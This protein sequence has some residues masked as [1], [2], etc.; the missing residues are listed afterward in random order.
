MAS[1]SSA[2]H[3]WKFIQLLHQIR[4]SLQLRSIWENKSLCNKTAHIL[5]VEQKLLFRLAFHYAKYSSKSARKTL[6]KTDL[7]SS[8]TYVMCSVMATYIFHIFDLVCNIWI[9]WTTEKRKVKLS[10]TA[11]IPVKNYYMQSTKRGTEALMSAKEDLKS[12]KFLDFLQYRG[13]KWFLDNLL[14]I[15]FSRKHIYEMPV[16]FCLNKMYRT[17]CPM[18]CNDKADKPVC[19]SDGN[20]YR[21]ECELKKLTCG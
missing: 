5:K 4:N 1:I 21:N 20:I 13:F 10:K 14:N 6:I 9:F 17:K 18:D 15:F 12:V 19:G 3:V 7:R 2:Q 8:S 11:K 16:P